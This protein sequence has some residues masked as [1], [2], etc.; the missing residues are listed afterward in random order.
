MQK[1]ALGRGLD[2]LFERSLPEGT[3]DAASSGRFL[4][5]AVENI[6]PNRYQPRRVFKEP[7]LRELAASLK[8][9]GVL[10]PV[11]V[12]PAEGGRFELI[13][14]ERRWRAAKLAGLQKIPAVLHEASDAEAVE[15]ALIENVQ[16][17]DLNPIE[18]AKAYRRLIEEFH[19]TQEDVA[20]RVG[21]E[22]SSVANTLRLL[23]LA[24]E[25]Q[26]AIASDR[27]SMGHA[28]VLLSLT[29]LQPQLRLA[30]QI[31]QKELS[32]RAAE[33]LVKRWS[34]TS[35]KRVPKT[36]ATLAEV[37][38]RLMRYLGTRVRIA[39][40]KEGGQIA[41]RYHGPADL[42]RLLELILK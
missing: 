10:Q 29:G 18:T 24:P 34:T 3:A 13:A 42:N 36:D 2:A 32:V 27:L 4:D 25:L 6:I 12:R 35:Q 17:Q 9:S 15:L 38:E 8:G 11:I 40:A 31:L 30:R 21:K 37:E 16:R 41:I 5:L 39:L 20:K 14:G 23:N 7:E 33:S 19:L 26:E 1:K 22:R 28:K